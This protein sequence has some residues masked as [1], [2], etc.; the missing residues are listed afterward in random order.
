MAT[1]DLQRGTVTFL[2]TDIEGSDWPGRRPACG[3]RLLPGRAGERES[4]RAVA[5][6]S[7]GLAYNRAEAHLRSLLGDET[8]TR[9][10]DEC[11]TLRPEEVTA[12]AVTVLAAAAATPPRNPG[13]TISCRPHA[14]ACLESARLM[15]QPSAMMRDKRTN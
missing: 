7:E 3:E 5:E 13:A 9:A 10:H 14:P 11:R 12:I 1:P 2:F 6:L 15:R 8:Y 4:G